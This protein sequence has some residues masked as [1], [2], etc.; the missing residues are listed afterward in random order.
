MAKTI[1]KKTVNDIETTA[2]LSFV[3]L[4]AKKIRRVANE[5][6]GK[7]VTEALSILKLLPHKG[8]PILYKL[9]H[10]AAA[11]AVENNKQN[12]EVLYISSLMV[13][14]G[15]TG[16]RYRARAR[17]RMFAI[18]RQTAHVRVAIKERN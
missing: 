17:G 5:V 4:S 14:E 9:I 16:K 2:K 10:S 1:Q 6:R 8:A 12:S 7:K 11:N 18:E 15:P 13:D 3:R